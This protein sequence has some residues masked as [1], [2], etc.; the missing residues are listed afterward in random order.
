M[1]NSELPIPDFED[2]ASLKNK[3]TEI[4][5]ENSRKNFINRKKIMVIIFFER[6]QVKNK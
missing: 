5:E 6:Q 2:F 3:K 1:R 4:M